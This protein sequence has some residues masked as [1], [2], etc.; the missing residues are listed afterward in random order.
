MVWDIRA[1]QGNESAKVKFDVLPYCTAGL[2]IGCGPTKVWP[3]LIGIDSGK[4]TDLF[5]IPMKPD[6]V[7]GDAKRMPLF[8]DES[9]E[10]VYS[11]H[12]LEHITE[13]RTALKEWWRLVKPGGHLIL[14]L[15][16]KDFYPNIGQPGGNPD[17]KHDFIPQDIIEAMA[18]IGED[19]SLLVNEERDGG[20]E[21][22]FLQVWRKEEKGHGQAYP[23]NDPKP[24]KSVGV[25]RVGG[26]GDAL[27]ASSIIYLLKQEGYHVTAYTAHTGAD[28]LRHDP[29]IDRIIALPDGVLTDDE[30]LDYWGNE[31][32]KYDK[33][34]NLVGSVETR[35]LAHGNEPS[36]YLPH[37]L[38]HRLMNKNYLEMVHDYA[39]L[40]H[41]FHQKFYPTKEEQEWAQEMRD[42]LDGPL[43]VINPS[44][45]GPVKY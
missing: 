18:F 32:P 28:I 39:D 25:V 35:L 7:V 3:H 12:T 34:V 17:H 14:Y 10:T 6:I 27:W 36:F 30:L 16:H 45:S 22:S 13:Y 37:E 38:R 42:K 24:E 9:V 2:D 21:Y 31:A 44:G 20:I 40:P 23:C 11:S 43:V 33:F 4:D 5:G 15:P 1:P 19:W 41:E 29:N 8:A 26:H